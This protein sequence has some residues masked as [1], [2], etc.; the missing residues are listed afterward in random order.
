MR[1]MARDA[2]YVEIAV[3]EFAVSRGCCVGEAVV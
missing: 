3:L 1:A 2:L